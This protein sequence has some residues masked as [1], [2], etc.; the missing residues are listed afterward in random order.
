MNSNPT[1]LAQSQILAYRCVKMT[2]TQGFVAPATS[3]SDAVFGVTTNVITNA[4]NPVT[5]QDNGNNL[6]ILTAG[7][8]I[9]PGNY[10]VPSTNGS[11]IASSTGQFISTEFASEGETLWGKYVSTGINL[12][13][14]VLSTGVPAYT[15]LDYAA[16][17]A[18]YG[19]IAPTATKPTTG[20]IYDAPSSAPSLLR[21]L[22]FSSVNNATGVGVRVVGWTQ[23]NIPVRYTNLLTFSQE[24][25]NAAW[26]KSN[27]AVTGGSINAE[28]APDGTLTADRVLE[29]GA[30]VNHYIG[31]DTGAP[32]VSTDIR[33]F[34]VYIK[35]GLGRDF[36]SIC[37]GNVSGGPYYTVTFNVNTGVITQE[38][39]VNT[40]T[41]FTSTPTATVTNVGNSWWRVTITS[42]RVQYYLISPNTTGT[43]TSGSNW[44]LGSYA[45]DVT[46]GIVTW[47]GQLEW[48]TSASPYLAT[49][50]TALTTINNTV[51]ATPAWFSTVLGDFTLSY[52]TGTVPSVVVNNNPTYIFSTMTQAAI[53]PDASIYRPSAVTAT[54]LGTASLLIDA[55]GHQLIQLQFK[56]N[57]GE[58]GAFWCS[59]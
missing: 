37:A 11:V 3:S 17:S 39:L 29:T 38:D 30:T 2:D 26:I 44:G 6:V 57:T 53:S 33:T 59:I 15:L 48:G 13:Q 18:S 16:A 21:V 55:V 58:M 31:R 19:S 27:L 14:V 42:R 9:A 56:A 47:G 35:G 12:S 54:E 7:G 41:W 49:T 24:F 20:I 10:L 23:G 22:P 45:S 1:I 51:H 36:A 34:S 40:G 50:S 5:L 52:T 25:D 28:T 8:P 46:K 32:G 43:P 4:N